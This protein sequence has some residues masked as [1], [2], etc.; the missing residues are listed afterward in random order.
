MSS[1]AATD[2]RPGV[3]APPPLI[4]MAALLLALGIHLL[5]PW[6]LPVPVWARWLGAG[7]VLL[8][9]IVAITAR[10]TFARQ[11]TNVNPYK[12][13]LALVT[14]GPFRFT[15]NPMYVSMTTLY[16]GLLLWTRIGWLL[17]LAPFVLA[18]MHFGVVLR[19]ER[20]LA[21]KFGA[22]YDAYRARV[23]RYL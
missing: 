13:A 17:L 21:R 1:A 14:A 6:A 5:A 22:E 23:R 9:V 3:I 12:P 8:A 7:L 2:D 19:E 16:V 15:R 18:L 10:M 20:Y 4:Y 11:G